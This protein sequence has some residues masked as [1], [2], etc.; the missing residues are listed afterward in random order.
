M[1]LYIKYYHPKF[2]DG[3]RIC[4][5]DGCRIEA[6]TDRSVCGVH[7]YLL[8]KQRDLERSFKQQK[9]FQQ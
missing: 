4:R 3:K 5:I 9:I 7:K 1:P 2:I 6:E 8:K